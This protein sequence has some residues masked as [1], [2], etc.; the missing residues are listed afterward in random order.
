MTRKLKKILRCIY[1]LILLLILFFSSTLVLNATNTKNCEL[2]LKLAFARAL[3]I[4]FDQI[5]EP[6]I[7][8]S[9]SDLVETFIISKPKSYFHKNIL[10]IFAKA[11]NED[12]EILVDAEKKSYLLKLSLT[13]SE[14]SEDISFV[15]NSSVKKLDKKFF[16][17]GSIIPVKTSSF[18]WDYILNSNPDLVSLERV[19]DLESEK[20]FKSIIL[21]ASNKKI[22]DEGDLI[23]GTEKYIYKIPFQVMKAS[24]KKGNDS[25]A[26]TENIYLD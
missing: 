13:E 26:I 20:F 18:F 17:A 16:K 9:K 2:E 7:F 14:H 25:Y 21:K 5:I 23:L 6:N 1:S 15:K 4:E 24:D 12:L 19:Y 11:T 22:N 3:L 10:A 8:I